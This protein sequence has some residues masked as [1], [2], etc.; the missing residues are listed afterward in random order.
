MKNSDNVGVTFVNAVVS[1]GILNN[2]INLSFSTYNFTPADE[3]VDP[4]PTISCRLRMDK[5]CAYQLRQVLND[6]ISLIEEKE[7]EEAAPAGET[8]LP[9]SAPEKPNRVKIN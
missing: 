7:K 1:R 8:P 3:A 9:E 6:L 2:V 5:V 4:D